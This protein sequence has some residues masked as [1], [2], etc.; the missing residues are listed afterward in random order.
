M[1]ITDYEERWAIVL[2]RK[3]TLVASLG[4]RSDCQAY[5]VVDMLAL[6]ATPY[7]DTTCDSGT[8]AGSLQQLRCTFG[9]ERLGW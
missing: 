6:P 1:L 2:P 5:P 9:E 8:S 7:E 4:S 3:A